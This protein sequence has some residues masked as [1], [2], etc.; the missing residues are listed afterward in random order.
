MKA[1]LLLSLGATAGLCLFARNLPKVA[2]AIAPKEHPAATKA[3]LDVITGAHLVRMLAELEGAQIPA[4]RADLQANPPPS[5]A[6]TA[7][8]PLAVK[9]AVLPA[10]LEAWSDERGRTFVRLA[11]G[12]LAQRL[13]SG[14]LAPI[15]PFDGETVATDFR[16]D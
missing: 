9:S 6:P 7:L 3:G 11:D 13:A 4:L 8:D 2:E 14:E 12:S 15:Q 5:P 10:I 1:L 16:A